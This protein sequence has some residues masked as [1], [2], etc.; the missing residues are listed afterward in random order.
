[1]SRPARNRLA[2][3]AFWV[4]CLVLGNVLPDVARL[5]FVALILLAALVSFIVSR[6]FFAGRR[7]L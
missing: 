6:R 2:F 1:M 4:V 5:P 7:A 3:A